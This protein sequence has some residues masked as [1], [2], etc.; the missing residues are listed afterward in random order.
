MESLHCLKLNPYAM[1]ERTEHED[2]EP[3]FDMSNFASWYRHMTQK[4]ADAA[5]QLQDH[6][7]EILPG[8][9]SLDLR[10]AGA[11]LRTLAVRFNDS[12]TSRRTSDLDFASP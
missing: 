10:S 5:S 3:A 8:F 12:K 2:P 9:E 1:S 11:N 4:R 7:R 6:L